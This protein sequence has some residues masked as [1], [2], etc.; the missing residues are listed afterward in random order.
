MNGQDALNETK[1]RCTNCF[2]LWD[3]KDLRLD[4][5]RGGTLL[6]PSPS[7]VGEWPCHP[8]DSK[9]WVGYKGG[10]NEHSN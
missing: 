1:Y 5:L 4:P 3:K 9:V 2:R 6:C 7:C 8:I 10:E